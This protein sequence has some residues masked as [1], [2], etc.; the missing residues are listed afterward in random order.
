M[1]LGGFRCIIYIERRRER[2]QEVDMSHHSWLIQYSKSDF[3]H[4]SS[5]EE[6]VHCL[7]SGSR[8]LYKENGCYIY[9]YGFMSRHHLDDENNL[10]CVVIRQLY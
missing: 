8:L 7:P 4:W 6:C 2:P 3:C 10:K 5:F 9:S 1:L